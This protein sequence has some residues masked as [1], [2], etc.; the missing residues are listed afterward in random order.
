LGIMQPDRIPADLLS[1]GSTPAINEAAL[2]LDG[3]APLFPAGFNPLHEGQGVTMRVLT[4]VLH[5]EQRR[6]GALSL[7]G[8]CGR[9]AAELTARAEVDVRSR[10]LAFHS[11][12]WLSLFYDV[13]SDHMREMWPSFAVQ[14]EV[15][16]DVNAANPIPADVVSISD[17][18]AAREA[19]RAVA[20]TPA[21]AGSTGRQQAAR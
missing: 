17:L 1:D 8:M 10:G 5:A 15:P 2:E 16:G 13:V 6:T 19:A 7:F 21:A 11:D 12:G 14:P 9:I 18:R 20:Y 4:E 3:T